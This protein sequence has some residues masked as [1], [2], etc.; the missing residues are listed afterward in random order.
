[1]LILALIVVVA[2][3]RLLPAQMTPVIALGVAILTVVFGLDLTRRALGAR[4]RGDPIDD[5]HHDH[6]SPDHG[7]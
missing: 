3:A 6:A 1:V 5:H 2:N 7:I 4:A